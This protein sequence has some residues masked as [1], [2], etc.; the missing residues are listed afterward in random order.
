MD[1]I[2]ISNMNS[3]ISSLH[4][5][6]ILINTKPKFIWKIRYDKNIEE[7]ISWQIIIRLQHAPDE[8]I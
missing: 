5:P 7:N 6:H 1:V 2:F 8:R 3:L 4:R